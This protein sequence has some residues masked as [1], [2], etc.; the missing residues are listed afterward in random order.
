MSRTVHAWLSWSPRADHDPDFPKGVALWAE[1]LD[2]FEDA[3]DQNYCWWGKV[4]VSG[5][6]GMCNDDVE[7]FNRQISSEAFPGGNETHLYMFSAD[8][9]LAASSLHV[10]LVSEVRAKDDSL[11]SSPHSPEFYERVEHPVPFWFKLTDIRVIRTRRIDD[12]HVLPSEKPLDPNTKISVPCLVIEKPQER[13]WFAEEK[14]KASG[15]GHWWKQVL[16]GGPQ[17]FSPIHKLIAVED[18]GIFNYKN[19]FGDYLKAA[20][21][22]TIVDP[23]IRN[24]NQARN[25]EGLL[26]LVRQPKKSTVKLI[27]M[28]GDGWE[29]EC[30][31]LLNRLKSDLGAK[32]FS[33]EWEFNSSIH[34]RLIETEKWEI[35]LGRGLDF[36]VSGRTKKCNI[37]FVQK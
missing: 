15:W 20:R 1:I 30:R 36:I 8:P 22:I 16:H 3:G 34:D 19:L 2:R 4:S 18:G 28:Y 9:K 21:E 13:T 35:H 37:F 25:V 26:D 17:S 24:Y 32:G 31:D 6:L 29:T 5:D 14:L 27:T 33:F 12:L 7:V 11:R 23:Y 10:G